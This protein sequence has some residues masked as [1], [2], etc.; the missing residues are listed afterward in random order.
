MTTNDLQDRFR[1]ALRAERA[2][3][4]VTQAELAAAAGVATS[5]VSDI[6]RGHRDR[7]PRPELVLAFEEALGCPGV[8][9]TA[10]GY[11]ASPAA[12]R[13]LED[14]VRRFIDEL[15]RLR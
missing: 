8:L 14:I 9:M 15:R 7:P 3:T 4:G 2:R 12:D 1:A 10:A 11:Q 5:T 6:E 13:E